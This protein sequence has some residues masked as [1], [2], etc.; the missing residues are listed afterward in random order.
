MKGYW[1]RPEETQAVMTADGFL[2][3][4]DIGKMDANGFIEIVDRLK[5]VIIASG[6][7]LF[8]TAIEAAVCEHPAVSE[9]A[10]IGVPDPYRGETAKAFYSLR[11]GRRWMPTNYVSSCPAA[12][13]RWKCRSSSRCGRPC[14]RPPQERSPVLPCARRSGRRP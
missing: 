7:K 14:R 11:P 4:G 10:V 9:V 1:N 2:R 13:R 5:D 3:T 6:Y 12:C 8:P